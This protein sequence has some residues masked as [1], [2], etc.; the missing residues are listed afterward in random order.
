[1]TTLMSGSVALVS[2]F[3]PFMHLH[4]SYSRIGQKSCFTS[5]YFGSTHDS[6]IMLNSHDG[7]SLPKN[8]GLRIEGSMTTIGK[9]F[10]KYVLHSVKFKNVSPMIGI[11]V[12]YG[13]F[14]CPISLKLWNV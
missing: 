2:S 6:K 1:M 4:I 12:E 14:V 3:L 13:H 8:I 11:V 5:V 10:F 9:Y 7:F